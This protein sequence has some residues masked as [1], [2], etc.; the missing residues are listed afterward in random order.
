MEQGDLELVFQLADAFGH[1]R[2]G[3]RKRTRGR[4]EAPKARCRDKCPNVQQIIHRSRF[5]N[6]HFALSDILD[7]QTLP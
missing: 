7:T 6:A 5:E 4:G 2:R 3:N 1:H